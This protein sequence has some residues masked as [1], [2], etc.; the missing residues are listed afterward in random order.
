MISFESLSAG[1]V[2]AG[3]LAALVGMDFFFT[4]TVLVA[5]MLAPLV[6]VEVVVIAVVFCRN[7]KLAITSL[8]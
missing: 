7:I 5:M 8:Y 6:E 2:E 4:D 1:F 3:L